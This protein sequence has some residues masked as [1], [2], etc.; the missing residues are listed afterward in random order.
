MPGELKDQEQSV[1]FYY[2]R[3]YDIYPNPFDPGIYSMND[4]IQTIAEEMIGTRLGPEKLEALRI[5]LDGSGY[6]SRNWGDPAFQKEVKKQIKRL[7]LAR[8]VARFYAGFK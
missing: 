3:K 4:Y 8:K 1:P 5:Q 7:F 6:S 2:D